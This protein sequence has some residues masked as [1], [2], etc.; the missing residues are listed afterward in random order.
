MERNQWIEMSDEKGALKY[1]KL[2]WVSPQGTTYLFTTRHGRKAAS[3][4][5]EE[6]AEWFRTDKARLIESE[7][8]VDRALAGMFQTA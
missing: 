7:P 6:L 8:I 4:T 3:L 2:A 5:P 1:A